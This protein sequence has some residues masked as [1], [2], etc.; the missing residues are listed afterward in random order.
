VYTHKEPNQ[1]T[2]KN[3]YPPQG[4]YV[5]SVDLVLAGLVLEVALP[6]HSDHL[7]NVIPRDRQGDHK[8]KQNGR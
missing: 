8:R 1:E 4:R 7:G 2:G 5:I 6:D 3:A